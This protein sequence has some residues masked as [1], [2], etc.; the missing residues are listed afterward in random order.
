MEGVARKGSLFSHKGIKVLTESEEGTW[1]LMASMLVGC[2]FP[3]PGAP[4]DQMPSQ[5]RLLNPRSR[6]RLLQG[7][8][9]PDNKTADPG[10]HAMG[11]AVMPRFIIHW[12]I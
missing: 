2:R 5:A 7:L 1:I 4:A 11:W 3:L 6:E 12:V 8:V 9:L 10:H